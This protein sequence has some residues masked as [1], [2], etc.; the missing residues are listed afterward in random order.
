MTSGG[1]GYTDVGDPRVLGGPAARLRLDVADHYGVAPGAFAG[2]E[3]HVAEAIFRRW[4]EE[5][6]VEAEFGARVAYAE[7]AGPL[8]R[9]LR[10]VDGREIEAGVFIDST[11]EGDV[12][13]MTGVPFAVGREGRARHDEVFAGRQELRPGRHA[14]PW[15]VSPFRDDPRGIRDGPLLPQIAQGRMVDVGQ[16]DGA[17]MAYGY[18][19]CLSRGKDRVPFEEPPDYDPAYWEVGRR[20]FDVI[21]DRYPAGRFIGLEQNLPHG[22][23]DANSLGPVSLNVLDGSARH[24]AGADLEHREILRSRHES[25]ARGFLWFLSS[26][27]RVPSRVRREIRQWGFAPDEFADTGHIPHQLYVREARRMVGEVVVTEHDLRGAAF[28]ADVIAVGSYHIDI[29]EVQRSWIWAWEHPAPQ[30]HVVNEGYLS[31]RVPRYG[32]PYR[33]ML[34]RREHCENLI[35]P[36]CI[37]ASHVAFASIRMEPQFEMLGHAAGLAAA[38]ACRRGIPMHDIDVDALQERLR[39]QGA[40]LSA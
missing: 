25:H 23:C 32:I 36:V 2:P 30:A 14:M 6:G 35:V 27:E 8:L 22:K 28:P 5:A 16:G 40:V 7:M 11:Y 18:R 4:L 13:A 34:P 31:V 33:A 15:G 9:R 24:W 1:L 21:G 17:V 39:G 26:D 3:P 12:M 37:A 38:Q 20:L 10:L 19:L 29:R